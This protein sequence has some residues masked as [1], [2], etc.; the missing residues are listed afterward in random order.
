[1]TSNDMFYSHCIVNF[2]SS[3]VTLQFPTQEMT[4]VDYENF[5]RGLPADQTAAER[6]ASLNSV[7]SSKSYHQQCKEI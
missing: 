1:M 2:E 5:V 6:R 3:T 7:N 4:T